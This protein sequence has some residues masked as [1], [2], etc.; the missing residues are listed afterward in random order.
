MYERRLRQS[1]NDERQRTGRLVSE[2]DR[3]NSA[4]RL[5]SLKAVLFT[6]KREL[7]AV[8]EALRSRGAG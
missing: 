3:H 6:A 1:G 5:Q 2:G 7:V 4:R 8:V